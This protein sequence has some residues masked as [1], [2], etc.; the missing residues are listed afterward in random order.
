MGKQPP[1]WETDQIDKKIT[2]RWHQSISTVDRKAR[3]HPNV[4]D[5]GFHTE[6]QRRWSFIVFSVDLQPALVKLRLFPTIIDT[7]D[8]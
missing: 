7:S 6:L 2:V 8:E 5:F 3:R 1:T 4:E